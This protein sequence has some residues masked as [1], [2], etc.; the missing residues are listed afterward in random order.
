MIFSPQFCIKIPEQN[1]H[2]LLRKLAPALISHRN[3]SLSHH[4]YPQLG[5]RKKKGGEKKK[6]KEK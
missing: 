4:I 6:T 3:C 5:E 2:A 1:I